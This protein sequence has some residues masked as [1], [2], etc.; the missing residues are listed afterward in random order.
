EIAAAGGL[1]VGED[2]ERANPRRLLAIR[3]ADLTAEL[4]DIFCL[5]A[6]EGDL[7]R[8]HDDIA[9]DRIGHVVCH[10]RGRLRQF[11]TEFPKPRVDF[12]AHCPRLPLPRRCINDAKR[13]DKGSAVAV[14]WHTVPAAKPPY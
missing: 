4:A 3:Y 12:P 13:K 2:V 10:R 7:A 5:A 6:P 8:H 1:E 9:A 14:Q 11:D